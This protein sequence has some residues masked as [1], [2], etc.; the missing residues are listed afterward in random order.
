MYPKVVLYCD[1][2]AEMVCK[3]L[4]Y[5]TVLLGAV[6]NWPDVNTLMSIINMYCSYNAFTLVHRNHSG[7]V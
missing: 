3:M 7:L 6:G 2:I 5:H 1:L 4:A